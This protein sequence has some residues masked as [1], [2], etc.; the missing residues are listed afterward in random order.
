MVAMV[1]AEDDVGDLHEVDL[2]FLGVVEDGLP[3]GAGV[4]EHTVAIDLHE[5]GESPLPDALGVGQHRR[6]HHD[7]DGLRR[8]R[9]R[10]SVHQPSDSPKDPKSRDGVQQPAPLGHARCWN[11]FGLPQVLCPLTRWLANDPGIRPSPVARSILRKRAGPDRLYLIGD[12]GDL[13]CSPHVRHSRAEPQVPDLARFAADRNLPTLYRLFYS[14]PSVSFILGMAS[15]PWRVNYDAGELRVDSKAREATLN[16]I[17]FSEPH[18]VHGL[19]V[20]G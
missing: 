13:A 7:L 20:L 6:E 19:S 1:V 18:R 16:I 11:H 10:L 5:R 4:K 9:A 8:A 2:E 14:V 15:R 17:D 3:T 12:A